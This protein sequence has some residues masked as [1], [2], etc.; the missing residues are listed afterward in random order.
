M[1]KATLSYNFLNSKKIVFRILTIHT[2]KSISTLIKITL[3]YPH[4]EGI[5]DFHKLVLD[6]SEFQNIKSLEFQLLSSA[7]L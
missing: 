4:W 7:Y 6:F 2:Q 5:T 3:S 1:K